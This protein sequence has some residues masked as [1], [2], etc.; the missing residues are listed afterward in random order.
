MVLDSPNSRTYDLLF[1]LAFVLVL[2]PPLRSW[3]HPGQYSSR[4][5]SRVSRHTSACRLVSA[6]SDLYVREL[7][8]VRLQWPYQGR[9]SHQHA[10]APDLRLLSDTSSPRCYT[11]EG[12]FHRFP[13]AHPVISQLST[14]KI[15]F[16]LFFVAPR[17]AIQLYSE[18]RSLT[19]HII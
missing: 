11:C 15:S 17:D 8:I 16:Y 4:Y 2:V 5:G 1:L 3:I 13:W 6:G 19:K 7:Y 9:R 12:S 14:S 10:H 18:Y